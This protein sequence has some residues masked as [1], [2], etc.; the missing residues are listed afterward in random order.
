MAG[1]TFL[2]TMKRELDK[3]KRL[4]AKD[5]KLSREGRS[6]EGTTEGDWLSKARND[7]WSDNWM[8]IRNACLEKNPQYIGRFWNPCNAEAFNTLV[9]VPGANEIMSDP[10]MYVDHPWSFIRE[11]A[12][13]LLTGED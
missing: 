6:L 8:K 11:R 4:S 3:F 2:Q 7:E 10:Q 5:G 12:N 1:K 13:K 9:N